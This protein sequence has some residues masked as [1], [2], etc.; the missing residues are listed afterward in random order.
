M[1]SDVGVVQAEATPVPSRAQDVASDDGMAAAEVVADAE[2]F[3]ASNA[4]PTPQTAGVQTAAVSSDR[5]SI[6]VQI[7]PP[8]QQAV[9]AIRAAIPSTGGPSAAVLASVLV[10][11]GAFGLF[12]RRAGRV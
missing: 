10:G 9:A 8:V 11:I 3:A 12:L 2:L 7:M 1:A 6:V 5:T 4:V